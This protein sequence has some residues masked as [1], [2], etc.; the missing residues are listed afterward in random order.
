ML[1]CQACRPAC[2]PNQAGMPPG[3][4]AKLCRGLQY[5]SNWHCVVTHNEQ[6]RRVGVVTGGARTG[7]VDTTSLPNHRSFLTCS[8]APAPGTSPPHSQ[9]ANQIAALQEHPHLRLHCL[10]QDAVACC[11]SR[12]EWM[13]EG[14][15]LAPETMVTCPNL[16]IRDNCACILLHTRSH[17]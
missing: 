12:R 7:G 17:R 3:L 15:P 8:L 13:L 10:H 4:L 1:R 6:H 2:L 11:Q 16:G 14:G 9:N 5:T